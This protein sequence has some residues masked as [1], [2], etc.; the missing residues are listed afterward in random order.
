[1]KNAFGQFSQLRKLENGHIVLWLLKDASWMMAWKMFAFVMFIPTLS[2]ALLI[3]YRSKPEMN[4]F[5]HNVSVSFWITANGCWMFS[6]FYGNALLLLT[7]KICFIAG[8]TNLGLH[9]FFS[10]WKRT[11]ISS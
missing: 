1:M 4:E 8:V 11:A 3:T 9:Y 6:E 7:A 5:R 2:L 10:Y